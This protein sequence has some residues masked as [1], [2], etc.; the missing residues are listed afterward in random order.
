[1][2]SNSPLF[3]KIVPSII[4]LFTFLLSIVSFVHATTYYISPSGNDVS[5]TGTLANPWKTLAKA[6]STVTT[7]GNI[8]HVNAGTY[9]EIQQ[10]ILAAGVSIEGDGVTSLITSTVG[11]ATDASFVPLID[12][13]SA[14]ATD[15]NQHISNLKFDGQMASSFLIWVGYRNNFSIYNCTIVNFYN[16]GCIFSATNDFWIT[17]APT[18]RRTGN[19][20]HDNIINNCANYQGWGRGDLCIGGQI[21]M[22][23]YNNTMI[24]ES[25]ASGKNGWPIKY[26]NDGYT[27]GLKIYNNTIRKNLLSGIGEDWS[28]CM[29][30]FNGQ[31]TEIYGNTIQ[32]SLDFNFQGDKGTYPY[33]LYI[34][35][36][37]I[38]IPAY[39]SRV[40]EG[41]IMEY[42][43]DGMIVENN[44][45]DHLF[46]LACFYP[47]AGAIIKNVIIKKNLC[48]NLGSGAAAAYFI[49]GFDAPNVTVHNL[50]I[51]NNTITNDTTP[52]RNGNFAFQMTGSGAYSWDSVVIKNN[53]VKGFSSTAGYIE[54]ITKFTNCKFQ[55]NDINGWD[56]FNGQDNTH[57]TPTWS[58]GYTGY[59]GTV[60]ISNNLAGVQPKFMGS[61]SYA[62][63]LTSPLIDAGTFVG[64][65]YTGS[66]P[67]GGYLESGAIILPVK[68]ISFNVTENKGTNLLKWTTATESNS[69]YFSIERSSDGQHFD[70]IG[71]VAATGFS[72]S[73]IN[74]HFT[75]VAP[76]TGI[77]YYRLIMVDRDNSKDY[78]NT[79]SVV[80]KKEQSLSI[81][82]ASVASGK[83]NM[84]IAV[85]SNQNQKATLA[86]F[87]ANGRL[88][89]NDAV[90]LQK[91]ITTINKTTAMLS[92]GVYYVRLTTADETAVKNIFTNE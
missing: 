69:D 79:V 52:N 49:G 23:V 37:N 6:T 59:P 20:F 80:N 72:S 73:D 10:S 45:F 61:G 43:V 91:G 84:A 32:G 46:S 62:L 54:D 16:M 89:F 12:A 58:T 87:D 36:N 70:A 44:T 77:N 34:H 55:F 67:D 19:S 86:L 27:Q 3:R 14:T 48:T 65:P 76:L 38:S 88:F 28:F 21:G 2:K 63:Q 24:Q 25:R 39:S 74:Y 8:I 30:I 35:D 50:Q 75:D 17:T 42:S 82:T 33:V 40:Q 29:E 83:G 9:A 56:E 51:L 53:I 15:G 22:L 5:G 57:W 90:Q 26:W 4:A 66:A 68:L 85:A 78:S 47:R 81:I 13:S 64:L 7:P 18:S 71:K 1:M 31:G 60:V 11:G 92:A 41:I